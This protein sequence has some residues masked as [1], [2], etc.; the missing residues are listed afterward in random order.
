MIA[1]KRIFYLLII[2][3][4]LCFFNGTLDRVYL[5]TRGGVKMAIIITSTAF[6]DGGMIPRDYTCD[7]R[8]IS[9]PL[10]WT[11][12][13][14]ETKS[15]SIICDD[16]DAPMGTWVHWVLFNIPATINGLSQNIPPDKVLRNGAR[17][18]INDFR[19]FGYGGPC[20]PSGTHRYYFK[21]YALDTKLTQESGLTKVE[22]LKAM[23][24]HI[25][26]EGQ[27]MGRY[28]R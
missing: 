12:V 27:L 28:K 16:P 4:C 26:A 2:L 22:L 13:P 8:D 11:G 9:P 6:T 21:I 23:K 5:K 15:L 19:K 24:D 10:T 17:H 25:L 3:T 20:P 1:R 18:G 7:G 14:K